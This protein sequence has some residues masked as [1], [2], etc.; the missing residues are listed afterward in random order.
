MLNDRDSISSNPSANPALGEVLSRRLSRRSVLTGGL[1]AAAVTFVAGTAL[2]PAIVRA[3]PTRRLAPAGVS[4]TPPTTPPASAPGSSLLGFTAVAAGTEDAVVV[5]DGYTAEVL[6]PWGTPLQSDGP[7]WQPDGSNTAADQELQI[8]SHHDGMYYFPVGED[9]ANT[10]GLLVLNHEYND[11]VLSYPDGDAEMTPEKAAKGVAAHGVT[12]V[13]IELVDGVWTAI[14]S[15]LNRRITGSTP[16]QFSGPVD[17]EN[18]ALQAENPPMGTLNNCGSGVT[19]WGTY[20]TCEE[21]FNG[22]FGTLD[23]EFE[24]S[25]EQDRY[26]IG[27]E[28]F[29]YRWYEADQRFDIAVNPNEA[30]RFGW[31]VEIDPMDPQSIPVK[32]T[33][34]G[35]IKHE[36]ALAT[37]AGG[38]VAVYMGDDQDGE[39]LYKFVSTNPWQEDLDA[40]SSPLDDGTL[41]VARFNDDGT[42]EW[43]PL[44]FGEVGLDQNGGFADQA[45]LLIRTREAADRVGA[46]RLDRPEWVAEN[47]LTG[48]LFV[49]LTNGFNGPNPVNPRAENPYGHIVRWVE[50]GGDKTATSF[51]WDVFVLAG[52]PAYD[53]EVSIDGDIFGSPD[54]LWV[55]PNGVMWIQTDISNSSQALAERGYDNIGNNQM[56]AA[57]PA[58]GEIRRFLVGPR[59]AEVT[60]VHTTPDG[61]TMFV[62]IQHP[63]ESTPAWGE[64][65]AEDPTAVSSWPDGDGRP[66]SATVVIRKDDGGVV[67]S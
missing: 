41:Y 43:M 64:T 31:V 49:T 1:G 52:D 5:P 60:G 12:I 29:G 53:P 28:D 4:T 42:G 56:L 22:Y 35:R 37:D 66:R 50:D 21:N 46:T 55:D 57:D 8:G 30:N 33:A 63:G 18:P 24:A 34:L 2:D 7:A 40:G 61:T 13:E 59:G 51:T 54:G 14:D 11:T 32:R 47:P 67:G 23:E 9:D 3:A 10:R 19:P 27:A 62:N 20:L 16:V 26:G 48:D 25:R 38:R 6:I 44:V 17:A 65:T 45:D 58:T 36:G 39:Y 15:E